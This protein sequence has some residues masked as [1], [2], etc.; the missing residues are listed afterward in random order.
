ML[1]ATVTAVVGLLFGRGNGG[2]T[3]NEDD[4]ADGVTNPPSICTTDGVSTGQVC[5]THASTVSDDD[6]GYLRMASTDYY[7]APLPVGGSTPPP[8]TDTTPPA[9]PVVTRP[10]TAVT[11]ARSTKSYSV[12]GTA[13][14]GALVRAWVDSN[15][16]GLEDPGEPLAGSTQLGAAATSWSVIANLSRGTNRF[17]V[18]ATDAAGNESGAQAVPA[19]TRK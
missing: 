5:N 2:S 4:K 19:I 14:A 12:R 15:G 17:V 8:P 1:R 16:N 9:P 13:E 18:T 3:T 6:G 11:V 7:S 10:T